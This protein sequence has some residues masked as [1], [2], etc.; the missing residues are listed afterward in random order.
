M[1]LQ[2][3]D[4]AVRQ[5]DEAAQ[6]AVLEACAGER[7]F[8][9]Q[10]FLALARLCQQQ[11]AKPQQPSGGSAPEK[12]ALR[13]ALRALLAQA[14]PDYSAVAQVPPKQS[15]DCV[16]VLRLTVSASYVVHALSGQLYGHSMHAACDGLR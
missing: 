11:A 10:D 7:N 16:P 8:G 12:A 4:L 1:R 9:P 13:A 5:G 2:E 6:L 15:V 3:F 14:S